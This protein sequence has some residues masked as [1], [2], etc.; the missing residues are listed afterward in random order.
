MLETE[1]RFNEASEV[2]VLP[3]I[4]RSARYCSP[5]TVLCRTAISHPSS[6]GW[7][8]CQQMRT[9]RPR[10]AAPSSAHKPYDS[11]V[12]GARRIAVARRAS[13]APTR[14]ACAPGMR[15]QLPNCMS[16]QNYTQ[17][18]PF[19]SVPG[20]HTRV[21]HEPPLTFHIVALE[22]NQCVA[23]ISTSLGRC[24]MRTLERR[25]ETTAVSADSERQRVRAFHPSCSSPLL[26]L[27]CGAARLFS[28]IGAV[29]CP[30]SLLAMAWQTR[31]RA[32]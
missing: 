29:A 17:A 13:A 18:P 10:T 5:R 24:Q 7:K 8:R 11:A 22:P 2:L 21:Q 31:R 20:S 25:R 23:R 16:K 6:D 30:L 12:R 9:Y 4:T 1:Q 28:L 27:W 26:S 3:V 19:L 15:R 32:T 14:L